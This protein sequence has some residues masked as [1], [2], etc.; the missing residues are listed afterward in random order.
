MVE[1]IILVISESFNL[2]S[3]KIISD[4]MSDNSAAIRS[5]SGQQLFTTTFAPGSKIGTIQDKALGKQTMPM[6]TTS[7]T[8]IQ[9]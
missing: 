8:S 6:A 9:M 2:N 7:R 5:I 3:F 1:L 4:P